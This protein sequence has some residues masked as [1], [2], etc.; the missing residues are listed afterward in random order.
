MAPLRLAVLPSSLRMGFSR[1]N[2]LK[3]LGLR[4][5]GYPQAIAC[6]DFSARL[7]I[8]EVAVRQYVERPRMEGRVQPLIQ[9]KPDEVWHFVFDG[10]DPSAGDAVYCQRQ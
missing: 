9:E 3:P 5:D 6:G 4:A 1:S 2:S 10:R 8:L 7:S